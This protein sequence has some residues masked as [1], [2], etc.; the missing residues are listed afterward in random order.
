LRIL[1]LFAASGKRI[2]CCTAMAWKDALHYFRLPEIKGR[3]KTARPVAL[4]GMQKPLAASLVGRLVLVDPR[5]A[6]GMQARNGDRQV[7]S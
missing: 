5:I 7:L 6:A 1:F 4:H 3:A 2:T